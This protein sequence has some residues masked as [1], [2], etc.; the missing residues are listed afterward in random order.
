MKIWERKGGYGEEE[1]IRGEHQAR[2]RQQHH[3]TSVL[4]ALSKT[5]SSHASPHIQFLDSTLERPA[6]ELLRLC[7]FTASDRELSTY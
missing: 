4:G 7:L 1:R 5:I 6:K 3:A 2:G